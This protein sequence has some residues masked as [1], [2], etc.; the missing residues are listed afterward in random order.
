MIA[1]ALGTNPDLLNYQYIT[2]ISPNVQVMML[3][4]NTPFLLPFPGLA[5]YGPAALQGPFTQ[6]TLVPTPTVLPSP[7]PTAVP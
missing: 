5:Q 7:A 2:K 3:P 4:N 1:A 6:P